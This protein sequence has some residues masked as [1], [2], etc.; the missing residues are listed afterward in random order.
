ML[1]KCKI[2]GGDLEI[3]ENSNVTVCKYCGT[4]QAL[5]KIDNESIRNQYERATHYRK[6]NEYDKAIAIY[7]NIINEEPTDCEIYWQLLLCEYGVEYVKDKK[8]DKYIPT[9][10]RTKT[11]SIFTDINYKNAI[12][13]ANDEQKIIYEKEAKE[14]DKIQKNTI[15]IANKEEPF[16]I[17]ICYKETDEEGKR[18]IDSVLAQDIYINLTNLGYKVFFAKITLEN[19]LGTEYEP[20]IFSALNSAKIM[21]VIGTSKEYIN[22][23]WVKNEWSRFL[24]LA[25]KDTEK[26]LIP[27]YKQM[28]PY[29]LPEEFAHLQAIDLSKIAAITDLTSKI[30][31]TVNSKIKS[32]K[33]NKQKNKESVKKQKKLI[34]LTIIISVIIMLVIIGIILLNNII[35]PEIQ[36]KK[37]ERLMKENKY[38]EAIEIYQKLNNYKDSSSKVITGV[39]KK[40][41]KISGELSK[42]IGLYDR[43][44][45]MTNFTGDEIGVGYSLE[46]KKVSSSKIEFT[47][48]NVGLSRIAEI[49]QTARLKEDTYE[50]TFEDS[51]MNKG[52][53]TLQLLEDGITINLEIEEFDEH[54][55]FGIGVGKLEFKFKDMKRK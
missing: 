4:E 53:G 23:V 2:C 46:I 17:F 3:K 26:L 32:N 9:C 6:N 39:V 19:K 49:S 33:K 44:E 1:L 7:E 35:M 22:S 41:E 24:N 37:A 8:T 43:T 29:D 40:E 42:Y 30:E 14:I 12:K 31:T 21:I 48:S 50:F 18:T 54:A 52:K 13:Y 15:E 51:W 5:P 47:L 45:K 34:K 20:Y 38:N 11:T 10:N 16:D 36:Y 27:T 55:M 28:D 25:K